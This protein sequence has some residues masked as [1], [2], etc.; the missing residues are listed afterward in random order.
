VP[1]HLLAG[2]I[3]N[4]LESI[5][6]LQVP[7]LILH[8]SADEAIPCSMAHELFGACK[9]PKRIHIVEGG[10]HGDL[11]ERDADALVWAISQFLADL[12]PHAKAFP[13]EPPSKLDDAI[14]GALR[15]VRPARRIKT[16]VI[17]SAPR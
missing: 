15:V 13:V 4:T 16:T 8:G 14:D 9:T 1:L 3:F 6:K 17:A 10:L 5:R 2:D 7:L 12:P 11:Y